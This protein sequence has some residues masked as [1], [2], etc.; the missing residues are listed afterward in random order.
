VHICAHR[1]ILRVSGRAPV[2]GALSPLERLITGNTP[3]CCGGKTMPDPISRLALA[4]SEIDKLFG[5]EL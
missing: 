2:L 5:Q 1:E 3:R 4:Q